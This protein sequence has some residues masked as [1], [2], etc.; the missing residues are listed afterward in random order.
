[1]HQEAEKGVLGRH[2]EDAKVLTDALRAMRRDEQSDVNQNHFQQHTATQNTKTSEYRNAACTVVNN[3]GTESSDLSPNVLENLRK[4]ME[5]N[6]GTIAGYR[7]SNSGYSQ[8]I[9]GAPGVQNTPVVTYLDT[10]VAEPATLAVGA[11]YQSLDRSNEILVSG[12]SQLR[13]TRSTPFRNATKG[14]AGGKRQDIS[15]GSRL[16]SVHE[17]T[18]LKGCSGRH[19]V[20]EGVSRTGL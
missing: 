19:R 5:T 17:A 20:G 12:A 2:M 11:H 9:C 3:R 1:L 8:V 6:V 13:R 16:A 7:T 18:S 15:F 4:Q 14:T 10:G